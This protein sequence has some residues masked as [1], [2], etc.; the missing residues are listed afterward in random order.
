MTLQGTM[1]LDREALGKGVVRLLEEDANR[2]P[3]LFFD[4]LRAIEPIISR[5]SVATC[6]SI[7]RSGFVWSVS[8]RG[9]YDLVRRLAGRPW[10][11]MNK[12]NTGI[13]CQSSLVAHIPFASTF[14]LA[15]QS[16]CSAAQQK[17]PS[18]ASRFFS[19]AGASRPRLHRLWSFRACR[20]R[21]DWKVPHG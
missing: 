19:R 1:A 10:S 17:A 11:A 9:G 8:L 4:R 5:D 13:P 18:S 6:M 20:G 15:V 3:V 7:H 21:S 12:A 2:R 14:Y 16:F